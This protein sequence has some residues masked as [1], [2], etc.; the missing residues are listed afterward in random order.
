MWEGTSARQLESEC[1]GVGSTDS[2]KTA[3]LRRVRG[4]PQQKESR[5]G[6]GAWATGYNVAADKPANGPWN[7]PLLERHDRRLR[8]P[9]EEHRR[10]LLSGFHGV[11]LP[12]IASLAVLA[13]PSTDWR[14]NRFEVGRWGS[15]LGIDFPSVKLMDYASRQSE[16]EA[17]DNPFAVVV[18]AHLATQATRNDEQDRFERKLA[19]TRRLYER[20][21]S[22]QRVIDLYRF[23]D[24][25]MRLPETLTLKYV[26]AIHRIE[27]T[28]N[29]PYVST[30]ER[31]GEARGKVEGEAIG[32][33][34]GEARGQLRGRADLLRA[35]L[36]QRFGQ[37]SDEQ[38]KRLEAA[39]ADQLTQWGTRLLDAQRLDEVF[40]DSH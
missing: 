19:L 21:L 12:R 3:R 40:R 38:R 6:E 25:I 16:L 23:I 18:L 30:I 39:D 33:A 7:Q 32:E 14:P 9:L 36:E 20:G 11:L 35:L 31:L 24:W 4:G 29:M 10:G 26:D 1:V 22:R 37:L 13:D 8:Q 17:D 27:E 15:R 2:R 34:R 28:M 5:P